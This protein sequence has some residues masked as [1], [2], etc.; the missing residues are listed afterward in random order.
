MKLALAGLSALG[1]G[2][3]ACRP[4]TAPVPES[5]KGEIP[6][7]IPVVREALPPI[8]EVQGPLAPRVVY[9]QANQMIQSKDS[10]FILGSV[11]NGKAALTI[12]GQNVP[13]QPNGSFL[14]FVPNPPPTAPQYDLVAVLGADTAR[15]T[16]PV[17]VA[18]MLPPDTTKPPAVTDTTPTWVVLGDSVSVA[19]DTDRVVIGRPGPNETYRW[20]F[21]PG[22]RA[23]LTAR[24]PGYARVRVDSALQVWVQAVDAKVVAPDTTPPHRLTQNGRVRADAGWS[25][26]I[27]PMG[28][29]PPFLIA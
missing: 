18:G 19:Q 9:P 17:R 8:P 5:K 1:V 10:T 4:S 28:E 14:A 27:I 21:F 12:N 25:D 29:R 23:L 11:G 6:G 22:T 15:A 16:Q 20:F 13:V 2:L 26:L 3:S 24:Y 7:E